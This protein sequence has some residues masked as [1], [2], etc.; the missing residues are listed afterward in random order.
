[1]S[2]LDTLFA[3]RVPTPWIKSSWESPTVGA[4]MDVLLQR[5]DQLNA[6]LNTGRPKSF[7]LPGFFNPQGFLTAVKQEV[8]RRH[9]GEHWALDEVVLVSQVLRAGDPGSLREGPAPGEGVNV[10]GLYLDGCSWGGKE[11]RL[12]DPEPKKLFAPLP[13]LHISALQLKDKARSGYFE[14][15]CYRV[16]RR[17][18]ANYI[19][20]FMLRSDEERAKWVHRGVALLCSV[21]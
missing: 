2:S 1:M 12:V 19:A 11:G 16:K 10:H 18:G 8:T 20:S 3:G 7:W 6:W 5:H 21:D 13:I 14:A 15:P 9:A 4:W 17:T